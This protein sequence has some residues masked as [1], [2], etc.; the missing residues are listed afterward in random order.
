MH[1]CLA[2]NFPHHSLDMG[3]SLVSGISCCQIYIQLLFFYRFH[4]N[5]RYM[6]MFDLFTGVLPSKLT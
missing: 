3:E 4:I 2:Y 1:I 6:R 5:L